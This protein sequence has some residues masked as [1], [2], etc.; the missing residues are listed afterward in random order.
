MKTQ[1]QDNTAALAWVEKITRLMDSQF[2]LPG[3]RFR[4]GLDPILGL[5]PGIGDAAALAISGGLVMTMIRFGA[6]RKVVI[7]MVLNVLLDAT[8]GSIPIIGNIFDFFYKANA[9]N[10][11]LLKDHY[12]EGRYQGSG[13]SILVTVAIVFILTIGLIIW[14]IWELAEWL[15][16]FMN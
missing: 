4:F 11:K 9:R 15:I 13:T 7:L 10:L 1:K 2:S 6:S 16:G 12:Q 8:L 5:L 3:T 14:G